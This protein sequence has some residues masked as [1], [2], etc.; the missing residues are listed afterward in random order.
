MDCRDSK[1]ERKEGGVTVDVSGL[2]VFVLI[3]P[4]TKQIPHSHLKKKNMLNF[5]FV[6]CYNHAAYLERT[7]A[8]GVKN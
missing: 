8:K 7:G 6:T 2:C 5:F 3:L 1:K 4:I